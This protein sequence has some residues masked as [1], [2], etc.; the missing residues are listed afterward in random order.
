M[1][2]HIS[3]LICLALIVSLLAGCGAAQS[4]APIEETAAPIEETAAP[5]EEPIVPTEEPIV[6]TEEPAEPVEETAA[7][8][9]R[10]D[11]APEE[12]AGTE[13]P[14]PT[15][16]SGLDDEPEPETEIGAHYVFQPKV[17]SSAMTEVFGEHMTETWFSLVDAIMAG[18]E[19]FACP[20]EDTYWWV[21][22]Q[23]P[24]QCFPVLKDLIWYCYDVE[25]PVKDGVAE[26]TYTVPKEEAAARIAEFASLVEGI[27]NETLRDDYSD[28]EKALALYLYFSHHYIY[29]Y[30]SAR[31]DFAPTYLSSYRVLTTGT[32]ICQEFSVA[33]SYL[34]LQA[35]VD[36]SVMSGHRGYD[37]EGHQW[38]YVRINGHEFHIDPTYVIGDQDSLAYFMMTDTQ[39]ENEDDYSRTDFVICSHYSN[40][41]PHPEYVADDETFREIWEGRFMEFDHEHHILTYSAYND[42]GQW[43]AKTFDYSGW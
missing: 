21:M 43:V 18:E 28:L 7:P 10:P 13:E 37:H 17:C 3:S 16:E 36:A 20:D 33:Y 41:H 32:G 35:G 19:T 39:R 8:A 2:K 34:L 6:P 30:E 1:K 26:F 38:S 12:P 14:E 23:Y 25:H 5:T 27:L 24:D 11:E 29:D 15:A 4:P 22:G 42:Q 9:E 31:P 40:D